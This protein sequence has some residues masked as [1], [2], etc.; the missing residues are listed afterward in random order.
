MSD[1]GYS[2]GQVAAQLAVSQERIR[3]LCVARRIEAIQSPGGQWRIPE[4]EVERIQNEGLPQL[5]HAMI[6]APVD[7]TDS[8]DYE[9]D[10]GQPR[11][12]R[13]EESP[14][15]ALATEKILLEK[16][17]RE[18]LENTVAIFELE[19]RKA[20]TQDF[21][22]AR[23]IER[24]ERERKERERLRA[25]SKQREDEALRSNWEAT[26]IRMI[27]SGAP[28]DI[29]ERVRRE[30]RRQLCSLEPL[31]APASASRTID[32]IVCA[33]T[34][35]WLR[36]RHIEALLKETRD[37]L[38]WRARAIWK[39]DDPVWEDLART[40]AAEAAKALPN[41]SVSEVRTAMQAAVRDVSKRFEHVKRSQEIAGECVL[42]GIPNATPESKRVAFCAVAKALLAVPPECDANRMK[43]VARETLSRLAPIHANAPVALGDNKPGT[44]QRQ[45]D[46]RAARLLAD[47]DRCVSDDI[48]RHYGFSFNSVGDRTEF[49]RNVRSKLRRKLS[50]VALE[51]PGLT[52]R[53][54][55]RQLRGWLQNYAENGTF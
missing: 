50:R 41:A 44:A 54:L 31:P 21:F 38:P 15:V 13:P 11:P 46:E 36:Q 23:A 7:P 47:L 3:A 1:R 33:E 27:P 22:D 34:A 28:P 5:P 18:T 25:E 30:V 26:A 2:T 39:H 51:Q 10:A 49:I 8:T 16:A 4:S 42:N 32:A 19:K 20:E 48:E 17:R 14:R 43:A 29:H 35:P 52:D 6:A 55:R 12:P 53:D 9:E 37:W 40:A 45:G 24:A